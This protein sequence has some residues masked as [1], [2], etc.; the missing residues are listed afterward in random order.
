MDFMSDGALYG[1]DSAHHRA[2][3]LGSHDMKAAAKDV[4]TLAVSSTVVAGSLS[5]WAAYR[6]KKNPKEGMPELGPFGLDTIVGIAGILTAIL[7]GPKLGDMGELIALGAGLG[8]L[9][10][11]AVFYGGA[12]GAQ[13]AAPKS[14]SG[15]GVGATKRHLQEHTKM[16]DVA[17]DTLKSYGIA[18]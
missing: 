8:G 4:M 12:L 9:N 5:A 10:C 6:H 18:A 14:V 13:M 15:T 3:H 1:D 7:A 17:R 2:T 11:A 16:S